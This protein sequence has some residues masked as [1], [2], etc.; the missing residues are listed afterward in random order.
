MG[1]AGMTGLGNPDSPLLNNKGKLFGPLKD[2][3]DDA[4]NLY[5]KDWGGCD[6]QWDQDRFTVGIEPAYQYERLKLVSINKDKGES[7]IQT[8]KAFGDYGSG[9]RSTTKKY[10]EYTKKSKFVRFIDKWH[11]KLFV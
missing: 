6:Y 1:I 7:F 2:F 8:G 5:F 10:N 11:P 9:I 4:V 3:A